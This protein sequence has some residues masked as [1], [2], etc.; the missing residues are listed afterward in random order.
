MKGDAQYVVA[1]DEHGIRLD[2]FVGATTR[3]ASRARAA[4]ALERGQVFVNGIEAGGNDAGRRL[5]KGDVVRIWVDRP[6]TARRRARAKRPGELHILFEDDALLVLDKPAGLLTVPLSGP[7]QTPSAVDL[8]HAHLRSHG[9]RRALVV[10]RIDRDTSGLVVFAKTLS[11]HANLKEQFKRREPER[12]YLAVVS[13]H[14]DP[15]E[16]TWRDRLI[17]DERALRQWA[18]HER[19]P[20]AK[21]AISEYRVVRTFA[22]ASLL[23]VR[24]VTGKQ[25]QIRVQAALRQHTLV[26]E[27]RYVGAAEHVSDADFQ[28]Q[29]LHAFRLS[30]HHPLHGRLMRFE[31]PVPQDFS[32]LLARLDDPLA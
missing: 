21:E 17:W 12:V 14:P 4:A 19:N 9:K 11:A 15:P 5:A 20:R 2:R 8:L 1:G 29:A 24:L 13:G 31:A 32:D 7:A 10:H 18:A 27:R 26:G 25:N 16:G 23:E 30:F 22:T 6:G 3:L 28:R